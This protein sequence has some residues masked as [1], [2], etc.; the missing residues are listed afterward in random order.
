MYRSRH[1]SRNPTSDDVL[2]RSSSRIIQR[3]KSVDTVAPAATP[4]AV[5]NP[6]KST[7]LIIFAK[8]GHLEQVCSLLGAGEAEPNEATYDGFTPLLVAVQ[9]GH[10]KIVKVLLKV[11]R[12]NLFF[13]F[14]QA[15][16]GDADIF[17]TVDARSSPPTPTP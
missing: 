9:E 15:N 8:I 1:K 3:S 17:V 4:R 6:S 2:K 12:A 13:F 5:A 10:H 16:L 7:E 11:F 14:F